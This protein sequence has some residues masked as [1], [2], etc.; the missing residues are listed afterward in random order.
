MGKGNGARGLGFPS[1]DSWVSSPLSFACFLPPLDPFFSL[2]PSPPFASPFSFISLLLR[3]FLGAGPLPVS[4]PSPLGPFLP[5]RDFFGLA[6][7]ASPAPPLPPLLGA[8]ITGAG[9]AVPIVPNGAGILSL[10]RAP[11]PVPTTAT[12]GSLIRRLANASTP[13]SFFL[14]SDL[15]APRRRGTG[16]LFVPSED[17]RS[18]SL[19]VIY[20]IPCLFL[21]TVGCEN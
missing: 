19:F 20:S 5:P 15:S 16:A 8:G 13:I 4:S 7:F 21:G 2:L 14:P 1:P 9:T 18:F 10:G 11:S 12:E 6:S 3:P 17:V